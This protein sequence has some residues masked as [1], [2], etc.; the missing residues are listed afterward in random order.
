MKGKLV[1]MDFDLSN[2]YS[3]FQL[4]ITI[5][6]CIRL[7]SLRQAHGSSGLALLILILLSLVILKVNINFVF[8][9]VIIS[10]V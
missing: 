6:F 10:N 5:N 8:S 9:L 2:T 7:S 4:P 1:G 3:A